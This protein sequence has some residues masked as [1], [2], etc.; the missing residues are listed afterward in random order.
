[1]GM[2]D[3]LLKIKQNLKKWIMPEYLQQME[4]LAKSEDSLSFGALNNAINRFIESKQNSEEERYQRVI[5]VR[6]IDNGK[7]EMFTNNEGNIEAIGTIICA[8]NKSIATINN[9][10]VLQNAD[11]VVVNGT[12]FKKVPQ[13]KERITESLEKTTS[14]EVKKLEKSKNNK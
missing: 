2:K 8:G 7:L 5:F 11:I 13:P 1:M 10:S 9:D 14:E 3:G 4:E 12:R 6:K